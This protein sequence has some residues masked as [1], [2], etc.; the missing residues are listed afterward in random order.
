MVGKSL[1]QRL[2]A[3]GHVTPVV[4]K[5]RETGAGAQLSFSFLC[6]FRTPAK[7]MALLS[8]KVCLSTIS[9]SLPGMLGW[10]LVS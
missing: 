7:A 5:Q 2:E 4:T 1:R 10:R 6:V 8:F 3:A 9:S